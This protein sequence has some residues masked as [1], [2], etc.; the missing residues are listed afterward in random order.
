[1]NKRSALEIAT[2]LALGFGLR[3]V[4]G[5]EP[6]WWLAWLLPGLVLALALR[7]DG[8]SA[9]G[10]VAIAALIGCSAN[11]AFFLRVMPLVPTM[12]VLLLQTV[13]WVAVVDETRRVMRASAAAWT[14]LAFP[15][16]WVAADT[17]LARLAPDGNW[18]SLA[19]TQSDVLPLAQVAALF[20]VGG[21]LFVLVLFNGLLAFT[22]TRGVRMRTALAAGAG[23]VAVAGAALAYG[24][25]RLGAPSPGTPVPFGIAVVD[26][27]IAGPRTLGSL[28]V[29]SQYEAQVLELANSG[30]KVI[31]LPEKIDVLASTDA[32]VRRAALARLAR[33]NDV[34]LVA[35]IGV[36]TGRERRNE[37]W[38]F[39]PDGRLVTNYL[40]HFMAPPEREFVAGA[41]YPVNEIDGVRYGVAICKDM[42]FARL[43][44]RF[45]ARDAAV[46]LVPAW[47]F[48]LD[49]EMAA[50]MTKLRGVENGYAVVRAARQG[51][52]SITDA[53]GRVLAV[54]RSAKLP[55]TAMF[56]TV[57]VGPRVPTLY[58]RIGDALGWLCVAAAL[59]LGAWTRVLAWRKRRPAPFPEKG[60][61]PIS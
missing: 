54:E 14:V 16:M 25:L 40:K 8:W 36:D 38:W 1:M 11:L 4:L 44:R 19:Y 9:R 35:G 17:L 21:I 57:P 51:L 61:D 45:G 18:G 2:A 26:D 24:I 10:L 6:V 31:L 3:F 52:L 56:A 34:W 22:V 41:E 58:T 46:M 48:G 28:N 23:T 43:G 32:E 59:G 33:D 27:V 29:W 49:A 55:G 5:L 12:I 15:V 60:S 47:D 7:S 42:H 13:L 20:G 50:N 39:G 30:A 53:Y 37:A